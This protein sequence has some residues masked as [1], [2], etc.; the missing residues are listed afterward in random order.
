MTGNVLIYL[1][2]QF[3]RCWI[4]KALSKKTYISKFQILGNKWNGISNEFLMVKRKGK[5][6]TT[7]MLKVEHGPLR[8]A[9]SWPFRS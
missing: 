4:V 2:A 7:L 3:L 1:R 9:K 8:F 6:S 5:E